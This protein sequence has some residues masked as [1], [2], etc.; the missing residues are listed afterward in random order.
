MKYLSNIRGSVWPVTR[1]RVSWSPSFSA[2]LVVAW[3]RES[4]NLAPSTLASLQIRLNNV[5]TVPGL[6]VNGL[7]LSRGIR[8]ISSAARVESGTVLDSP[9]LV[10]GKKLVLLSKSI[11]SHCC[12]AISESLIA[13][14]QANKN[15][16]PVSCVRVI[17]G[18]LS[19]PD[20]FTI[21][22]ISGVVN[23]LSRLAP[24]RGISKPV[25]G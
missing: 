14:S 15:I 11:L 7:S 16:I 23:I 9:F 24:A 21:R 4:W 2:S 12:D 13:V 19:A 10:S 18:R 17:I 3:C 1:A 25:H 20:A 5:D 8:R 22:L 6:I